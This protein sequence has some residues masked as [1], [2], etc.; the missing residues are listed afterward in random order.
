MAFPGHRHQTPFGSEV[1]SRDT[2]QCRDIDE[3]FLAHS[4][5]EDI[6]PIDAARH[7]LNC[8]V[9]R[10]L[11]RRLRSACHTPEVPERLRNRVLSMIR[12]SLMDQSAQD[13]AATSENP[14]ITGAAF[15]CARLVKNARVW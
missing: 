10:A 14:I 3:Y 8:E 2:V 7:L 9:C 4:L 13:A 1:P 15:R 5:G 6:V 11:Y 12:S